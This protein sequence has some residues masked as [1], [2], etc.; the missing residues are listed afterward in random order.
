MDRRHF[1]KL[2]SGAALSAAAVA[3][4]TMTF[5]AE[6]VIVDAPTA[7]QMMQDGKLVLVDIRRPSEWRDTGVAEGALEVTMH[8]PKGPNGFLANLVAHFGEDRGQPIGLICAA[9]VRSTFMQ[10]FLTTN[11]FTNI[12]NVREGML[13]RGRAPGW[14]K[15][16]LPVRPCQSCG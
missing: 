10:R 3:V 2:L 4:P 12:V 11:G 6:D 7:Y 15:R 8:D 5:A 14:I 13:G 1:T 16:G 9:G